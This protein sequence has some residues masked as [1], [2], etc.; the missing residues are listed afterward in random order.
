MM[1]IKKKY[2]EELDEEDIPKS[3]ARMKKNK[4]LREEENQS[5]PKSKHMLETKKR[6]KKKDIEEQE[7]KKKSKIKKFIRIMLLILILILLINLII[8]TARWRK[9]AKDMLISQN[10]IV[11]DSEG[12]EIAQIGDSKIKT[13]IT[14]KEI[15]DILKE[16]YV[17]IEDERFY[18]HHGV[19]G[20]RTLAATGSYIIHFGSSSFGGSTITQQLVKNMTGD[21]S[22]SVI[23]KV[24]EWWKAWNLETCGTKDEILVSYLNTIY[25]G[26]NIYGV[27]AGAKY[28]FNKS[29]KEL[30]IEECAFLAGINHSPNSYNPYTNIDNTEKINK[31]TK[32][33]LKKLKEL[34][35]IS[36]SEYKEAVAKVDE[37][38]KFQ[39]A[40]QNSGDGVYSYHTDALI[41]QV[42]KEISKKYKISYEFAENY[43]EL[44]GATIYSTQNT[45]I[46][47]K[48][49]EEF[50]KEKYQ[51]QSNV[52]GD[53]S[54]AAMV[55]TDHTTGQVLGCVGGLG[56]KTETRPLNRATQSIRQTGSSI[57]PIAVVAPA[58]DKKIITASSI[59][60]DTERD[61]EKGYHPIDYTSPLGKITV[62]R[63]IESSQN[64][65]FVEI[66]EE[67]T[68]KTSI[69][70]L[71]KM[72]ISTLTEK[73]ES[74]A[75]A[76][77]GVD[78]GISP[79]E[80]AGAYATIA[81]NGKY[82]EP[83]FYTEIKRNNGKTLLKT[84]QKK[85][86]VFSEEVAYIMQELLTQPITGTYGTATYCGIKGIDI[87]AKT[88][89]TDDNFDRWL[90]GFS[91]YYTCVCW[92]G[93]DQAESI[94][95]NKRNPSGLLWANV[96]SKV[97]I[98]LEGKRFEKPSKVRELIVC[99]ETGKKATTGC[100]STHKE[101]FLKNT[102]PEVCDKHIGSE[103]VN[104]NY[105]EDI[106]SE[107]I[108][109]P[110]NEITAPEEESRNTEN[111]T[112]VPNQTPTNTKPTN[113]TTN[114]INTPSSAPEVKPTPTTTSS[115]SQNVTTSS[116]PK[117]EET[118]EP[119]IEDDE[120]PEE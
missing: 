52:G 48:I 7:P 18:K 55:I 35:K 98:G 37:G 65:P 67:L 31:R 93:Y 97:H 21:S 81:N 36:N 1:R 105:Y 54:Q 22:T 76:L 41:N 77:G 53:P 19:D 3:V 12:N 109:A 94:N 91:P 69:K 33:V 58:I 89:T 74:L 49:E 70:Y 9:L 66:M 16:A 45:N 112:Q 40:E 10:S 39:K 85:T 43:L 60:D 4:Q 117:P 86:K 28:Y 88:G 99:D 78:K 96:M 118:P 120:E 56:K 6:K 14:S 95:Y 11:I 51:I 59:V 8:S 57:K 73:D 25:V 102:E 87:A 84:K 115:P 38:L 113:E 34:E 20:K 42:T 68:P 79:L 26:P 103:I 116:S 80:M 5:E 15:P 100:T 30:T 27:E 104:S 2:I 23:R 64:V 83:T 107:T 32:T 82:I 13:T 92:Y 90:C 110:V 71:K 17:A 75:L 101:Y 106:E 44:S 108:Q 61:F 50:E 119:P 111:Q 46:Q 114:T 62:R 29:A 24:K 47:S 72:G 63:A